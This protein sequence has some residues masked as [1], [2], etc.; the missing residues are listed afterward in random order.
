MKALA[1]YFVYF[2]ELIDN[3]PRFAISKYI[4]W[5]LKTNSCQLQLKKTN[6]ALLLHIK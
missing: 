5:G 6:P 4:I 3:F 2:T 1:Y